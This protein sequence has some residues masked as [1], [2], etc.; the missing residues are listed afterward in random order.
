MRKR[1]DVQGNLGETWERLITIH[2]GQCMGDRRTKHS[3]WLGQA[4]PLA[5]LL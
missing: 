5:G 2:I 1:D 4:K 3:S